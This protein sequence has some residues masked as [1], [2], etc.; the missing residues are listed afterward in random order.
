MKLQ[1]LGTSAGTPTRLRN[2]TA[3][4]LGFEGRGDWYLFDCGEATQHQLQKSAFSLGR[5]SKIFITH[6]HGDHIFGLPGL[7]TSRS[8]A[9]GATKP[10]HVYGPKG[11]REF[12]E[13]SLRL[14]ASHVTYPLD[15]TEF[16]KPG[17]VYTDARDTVETVRLSHDI[18]SFAYVVREAALPG[19]FD[20][21]KAKA[22]G[23][24]SGP[25]LGRLHKGETVTMDDGT[26]LKGG[27]FSG[28]PRPGRTVI[29]GGD[30]DDPA[31]LGDALTTADLFIHE[32][33]LTEPVKA[34]L[35]FQSRHSTAADVAKAAS[36]ADLGNL[37]LTHIS[38]RYGFDPTERGLSVADLENEARAHFDGTLHLARDLDIYTLS[39]DGVLVKTG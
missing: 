10:I 25:L 18:P 15:I 11:I 13:T 26:E 12:I 31:L 37:I 29:I 22:A 30:N 1:F 21:A 35:S 5:L 39:R 23:V 38:P 28:P 2:V 20:M 4:A 3:L 32:A 14:S 19:R 9:G 6:L 36:A 7:L 16:T 24:P 34:G 8:M 17:E 27:E 33:T